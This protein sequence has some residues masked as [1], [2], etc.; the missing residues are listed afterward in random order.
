[1]ENQFKDE[2]V[3]TARALVVE[4]KG[5]LA[6]DESSGSIKKR[7]EKIG[8]EDSVENHRKY[9]QLLLET[10]GIENYISGVI[11]FDETL[12]QEDD[13]GV[14]FADYLAGKGI[15][16]GIKI[17][18]G[19]VLMPF[20]EGE[21]ITEGIDGLRS[22][23]KEYKELGARFT[24]WRGVVN[25]GD[26]MPSKAAMLANAHLLAR[27]AAFVQEAGLVPI[28]EPEVLMDGDHDIDECE[29]V[30]TLMLDNVFEQLFINKVV[31]EGILLKPNMIVPGKDSGQEL[32]ADEIAARTLRVLK[33]C[34]PSEV[35]GVV[36]LSGGE[37]PQKAS[38]LLAAINANGQDMP[39]QLTFS[40]GRALQ[41][42]AL[43]AWG[44]EDANIELAQ[45][46]FLEASRRN[47][48][49][50]K[51]IYEQQ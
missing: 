28:V 42:E 1:M 41:E 3:K 51:G 11:L 33:K 34:V 36:F 37:P 39:W 15:I 18:Q 7:F 38:E 40:F 48:Q 20:S 25:I 4:G 23:L 32:S 9:R 10:D 31:M 29:I 19:K 16:P 22:R 43:S 50:S 46:K 12:R 14:R 35:Q 45:Q 5:I 21:E 30:T 2:L 49:A 8:V 13:N 27:Q 26:N 17:D 47:S 6:A 44:G 24:K